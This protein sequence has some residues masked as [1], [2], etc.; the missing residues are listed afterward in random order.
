MLSRKIRSATFSSI[1][2]RGVCS[3]AAKFLNFFLFS[4]QY[5]L[6]LWHSAT[7]NIYLLTTFP[8][9]FTITWNDLSRKLGEQAKF[10]SK[11]H[12]WQMLITFDQLMLETSNID[13]VLVMIKEVD[14]WKIFWKI[15]MTSLWR[16]KNDF[17]TFWGFGAQ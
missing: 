15:I 10:A 11:W 13:Q 5:T 1:T 14:R 4:R 16:H 3:F 12:F 2:G 9:N 6:W 17:L 7:F 8:E